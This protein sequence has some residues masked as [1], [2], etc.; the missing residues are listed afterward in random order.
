MST[1]M[2]VLADGQGLLLPESTL[3]SPWF[4]VLAA[5][6][7]L[8]TIMYVGL[9]VAQILPKVHLS[10]LIGRRG[11]RSETRSIHPDGPVG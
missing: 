10:D 4:G 3:A 11:R 1:I 5:F 9:A 8:N 7:A 6:V 2:P